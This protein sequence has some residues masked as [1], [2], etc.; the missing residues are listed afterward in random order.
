MIRTLLIGAAM[1]AAAPLFA[2]DPMKPLDAGFL[3]LYAE[4]RGFSLGR[5]AN[6]KPTPDGKHVLFLRSL[7]KSG[8]RSL[9]EFD[10]ATGKTRELLTADAVLKGA[11][12]NLSPE[13]K[14]RRER[15]RLT[16]GGFADFQMD[17]T[18]NRLLLPLS[19]KL[20][21]FDCTTSAIRE[22]KTKPGTLI[23]PKWSP[24]HKSVS[25]VRDHDVAVYNLESDTETAVTA[26]G[27]DV[28][29]NGL[30]EFVA[31][32]EMF[33]F[34]GYWWSPDSKF[35]AFEEVD[36]TG[37]ETW[38]VA[39]PTKPDQKPQS[40]YYPRPGKKNVAVRLGIVPVSSGAGGEPVWVKWDREKSE[41]LASVRWDKTGPLTIQVQD[42]KQQSL[43][44]LQVDPRSGTTSK[45]LEEKDAAFTNLRQ[46]MPRFLPTGEFLWVSEMN[47]G[48]ELQLRHVGGSLSE[49]VLKADMNLASVVHW[50]TKD[51]Q[52]VYTT[53]PEP[54]QTW[55]MKV[56]FTEM[57]R[58]RRP[59]SGNP[60]RLASGD[61]KGEGNESIV[62]SENKQ[63]YV[64]TKTTPQHMPKSY[65]FANDKL[66][67]ELPGVAEEPP[68]TPNVHYEL[69]D[70]LHT[71]IIRPH[72]FDPK[73][74]Y[75]VIVDVY[76]GPHHVHVV[77]GMRNS[78][79]TQW[80][81]DQGF[82]VVAIDNKGTPGRGRDWERVIYQKFGEIPL[83]D[84]VR[85]LKLLGAKHPEMDLDR[86]GITGWSFGG[87]MSALAAL[88]RPDVYKAAVA[89]A[90]VTD[91][92]DYDTHYTERYMGL[93][94]ESKKQYDDSSLIPLAPGLKVPLLLVHGTADDNVYFRHTLKLTDALFRAGREFDV[95]PL[96]GLTH[97]VPD[98]VVT[99]RLWSRVAGHFQKHLGKAK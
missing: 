75:P 99:E 27:T 85:G 76:G 53:H 21:L 11:A 91:W 89:G 9:Y 73:K 86:V 36:H 6:P 70:G 15:M 25:Y 19:G 37:V 62:F 2:K 39:D 65:V 94:P 78:L 16:A 69:I 63:V 98:P 42:R 56:G 24:D 14:A 33:R 30:A 77:K 22:L 66:V 17:D 45:L 10:V 82:I 97:M 92:E 23:D 5:P 71:S 51:D 90:P 48:P 60:V 4:T 96:P 20:Y 49:V 84:Q 74:K 55:V 41:Y 12:E 3:R 44:L 43:L 52:L 59:L 57:V 29:P 50:N 79:L 38:W 80:L 81:A 54:G 31:Q 35:I 87:Y 83:E 26:G 93:L 68:F 95:L 64:L 28:K 7:P 46:D 1:T 67:G 58:P 34:T 72:G 8:K 32:E 88:K 47:Q 40:Q 61:H 13:E 18:G